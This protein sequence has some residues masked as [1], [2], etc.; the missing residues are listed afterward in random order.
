MSF[1]L[2]RNDS[3]GA[4]FLVHFPPH[5]HIWQYIENVKIVVNED[6]SAFCLDICNLS[7]DS[8]SSHLK[9]FLEPNKIGG[10][11]IYQVFDTLSPKNLD[12]MSGNS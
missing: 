8:E 9:I 2:C 11:F 7:T 5:F 12:S 1:I 10:A 3:S 6:I 4:F